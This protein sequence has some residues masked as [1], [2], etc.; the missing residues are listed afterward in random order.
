MSAE[1]VFVDSNVLVY[2]WD[3]SETEKR[4]RAAAWMRHLW[5]TKT[6]RLSFQVLTEFYITVTRKLKPGMA[7]RAAQ[8]NV[9]TLLA[10]QPVAI[11]AGVMETAFEIQERY[12]LSYWDSLVVAAADATRSRYLLSEDFQEGQE[13]GGVKVVNPFHTTPELLP[14]GPSRGK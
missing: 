3:A 7:P 5:E 2:E 10:W 1:R 4:Q 6:G 13:L 14:G 8:R 9:R 11:D 12:L